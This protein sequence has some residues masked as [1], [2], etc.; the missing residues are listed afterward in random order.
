MNKTDTQKVLDALDINRV[1]AKDSDGNYTREVTPKLIT[2]AIA[3]CEASLAR[4]VEPVGYVAPFVLQDLKTHSTQACIYMHSGDFAMM[5]IYDTPQEPAA[6][7]LLK[8]LQ[9]LR[10]A[11]TAPRDEW[12]AALQNADEAIAKATGGAA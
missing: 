11:E 4:V 2:A 5:P 6:P 8:A 1:M 9:R 3:I 12:T 10:K 7:E